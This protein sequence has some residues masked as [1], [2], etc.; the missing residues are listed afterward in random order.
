MDAVRAG[1]TFV[2]YGPLLEFSVEGQPA[3]TRLDMNG[4][5]GTVDIEWEAA[6]VTIPMSRIDL[7]VNGE[8]R[9][10]RRL[11][12]WGD[13]GHWSLKVDRSSWI[14]LLV[15]GHYPDKPDIVAAHSS[16]VTVRVEGSRFF[17]P[18]D[19]VTLLEQIEGALAY[20]DTVGTRAELETYKRMRL[21][22]TS[23]HR[24]LHNDLHRRGHDHA[25]TP[26]TDHPEHHV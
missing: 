1:N 2:T 12:R 13:K 7:V 3:G 15:R 9:K 21:V 4:S 25:H 6:S 14:A 20:L 17:A 18:A 23:V 5:G 8:I 26:A 16:P 11:R 19:A 24:R 10:S 22:L